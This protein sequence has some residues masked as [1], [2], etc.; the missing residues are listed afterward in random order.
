MRV[1]VFT[2]E[3]DGS[4]AR[5]EVPAPPVKKGEARVEYLPVAIHAPTPEAAIAKAEAFY[6]SEQERFAKQEAHAAA[7]LANLAAARAL[8]SGVAA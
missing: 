2:S 7:R 8:K 1:V 5:I 6:Q 3:A 4:L